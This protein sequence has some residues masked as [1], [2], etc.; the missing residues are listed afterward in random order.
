[1]TSPQH[2]RDSVRIW[3]VPVPHD[4]ANSDDINLRH[5]HC[6]YFLIMQICMTLYDLH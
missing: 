3:Q 4:A 6:R 1:M 5:L 2:L